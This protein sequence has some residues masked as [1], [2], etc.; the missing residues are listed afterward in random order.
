MEKAK[1][2][3]AHCGSHDIK[4]KVIES[5]ADY[6]DVMPN[7]LLVRR[8][9]EVAILGRLSICFSGH[10]EGYAPKWASVAREFDLVAHFMSPCPCG[11]LLDPRR[12]CTCSLA[13]I[14]R[15]REKNSVR[16][17]LSAD[18]HIEVPD[19]HEK[20]PPAEPFR[21]ALKRIERATLKTLPMSPDGEKLLTAARKELGLTPLRLEKTKSAASAIA[22]LSD[23]ESV[24]P[25]HIAEAI[26]YQPRDLS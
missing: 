10:P 18:L 19:P 20:A 5:A 22:C 9:L 23:C 1:L 25:E 26:Q 2:N 13:R 21:E 14:K 4:V 15:H 17:A 16:K 6:V 24:G 3:C 12:S 11:N 7:M 8:V